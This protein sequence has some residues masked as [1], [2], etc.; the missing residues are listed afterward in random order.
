MGLDVADKVRRAGLGRTRAIQVGE[1]KSQEARPHRDADGVG[2][3]KSSGFQ[4][5]WAITCWTH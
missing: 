3:L 5:D 1:G 4:Q 2:A